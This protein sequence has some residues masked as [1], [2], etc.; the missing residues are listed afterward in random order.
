MN[1]IL[2]EAHEVTVTGGAVRI[3][4]R[5]ARHV[6]EVLRGR[7]GQT[8]RVGI[9]DGPVGEA[10]IAARD[11]SAVTLDCRFETQPPPRSG[12]DLVLAL[13]RPKAMKRLWAMLAMLGADRVFL[14]NAARVE[15]DYFDTQW[16]D[17][18]H[19]RPLLIE[20]LEQS[21][22]TRMP[23]VEVR[24]RLKPF[25][26]DECPA[27]FAGAAR[28]LAQPGPAVGGLPAGG[29]RLALAVGPEGGW[30]DYEIE[31]LRSHGFLCFSLGWRRLR[32]DVACVSL[33][34]LAH[35][36]RGEN[37]GAPT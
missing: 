4:G 29:G 31:L 9:L 14:V 36:A 10:T 27:L 17:P 16:I 28:F 8:V 3:E 33:M 24:R 7:P 19:L 20:G 22:D 5:R 15:R 35:A 2:F 6:R 30:T 18:V 34:A 37:R 26:E 12:I 32:T 21:G 25:V 1:R 11:A 23:V 13:P